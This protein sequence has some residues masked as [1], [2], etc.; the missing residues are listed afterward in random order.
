MFLINTVSMEINMIITALK[1]RFDQ[2][3][4]LG[5]KLHG[6]QISDGVK[7]DL[8]YLSMQ[9]LNL[10]QSLIR[11][12]SISRNL[13]NEI[14]DYLFACEEIVFRVSCELPSEYCEIEENLLELVTGRLLFMRLIDGTDEDLFF[15]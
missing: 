11:M 13:R 9:A 15:N 12:G 6:F 5:Q 2:M 1:Q 4:H 3:K 8:V 14:Q 10:N 7:E